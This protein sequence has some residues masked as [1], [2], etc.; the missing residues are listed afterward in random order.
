M[1]NHLRGADVV[2]RAVELVGSDIV[3]GVALGISAQ[4]TKAGRLLLG[5]RATALCAVGS[6]ASRDY[7]MLLFTPTGAA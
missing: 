1:G 3:S 2:G 6:D 7:S 5:Q 4:I